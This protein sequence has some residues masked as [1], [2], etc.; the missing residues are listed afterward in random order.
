MRL[1]GLGRHLQFFPW[2]FHF[3]GIINL[4]R[5]NFVPFWWAPSSVACFIA[6][7]SFGAHAEGNSLESTLEKVSC[8][9]RLFICALLIVS[10][11]EFAFVFM[12]IY[13]EF[14]WIHHA[15]GKFRYAPMQWCASRLSSQM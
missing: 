9:R 1:R 7:I 11:C 2:N 14:A 5:I 10:C 8:V 15:K 3:F 4:C 12:H 6:V 13:Y